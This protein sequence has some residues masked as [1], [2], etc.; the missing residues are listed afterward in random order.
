MCGCISMVATLTLGCEGLVFCLWQHWPTC[1][2]NVIS[3]GLTIVLQFQHTCVSMHGYGLPLK[4]FNDSIVKGV[5]YIWLIMIGGWWQHIAC[6]FAIGPHSLTNLW[7]LFC[8]I[9]NFNKL[10]K[11]GG[12]NQWATSLSWPCST[13]PVTR[14]IFLSFERH[15]CTLYFP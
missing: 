2:R 7:T 13:V 12:S 10:T 15:I 9:Q 6:V 5:G 8:T 3:L 11:T 1:I 4:L 14:A